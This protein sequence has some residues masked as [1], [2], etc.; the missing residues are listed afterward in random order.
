MSTTMLLAVDTARYE[1]GRHV[2]AAVEMVRDLA[3]MTGDRVVVLHVHEFASGRFGRIQLDCAD[4]RGEQLASGIVRD[5]QDAGI[6]AE[7]EIGE[8]DYG[9]VARAILAAAEEHD[10]RILVLGSS[11][12]RDL[13]SIPFGSVAARLLHLS[14]R[15]VLIVPVHSDHHPQHVPAE[16]QAPVQQPAT[17]AEAD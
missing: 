15:P 6:R 1:R 13:P 10:A 5:L 17:A 9:H 7:A 14:K 2:T 11:T 16:S 8:A 4:D 12:N 3:S